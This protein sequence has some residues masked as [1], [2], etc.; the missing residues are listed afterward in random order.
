MAV[1]RVTYKIGD[2]DLIL[3]TGKIG[4]QANGCVYAQY[5]GTS[6]IATVCASSEVKEGLD[7]VPVTVEYNEKYYAA[8]KIPGG[9][10]KR[11]GRPKDKE[12]LVSR[13]IDRPMRPLFEPAFGR[14]IQI[15]PTC[16]SADGINPPDILAV[17]ASSAAVSISDIPFHG[18]V[19]AARVAYIDGQYVIN[20]TFYQQEKAQLE[21]VVAGTK[22]GFT[23]VEGG[24]N[25]VS[26]EVMLG[27]LEQAQGFITAMCELQEQLVA[28]CGKEKLPLAP[29]NV[30]L[31]NKEQIIADATPLLEKACF[32]DGKMARGKAIAAAKEQVAQKYAEQLS[33]EIQKK[34]FDSCFDDIQYNLLR[35]SILD[36]GLRIDGRK[37]DEIRPITCEVNVL[38][39]PHGSA[40]FTRGETQSLA[41]CTLGT[42][43]DA[44]VYDDIDGERS[45]NFILHYN[46]PPYSVGEVGRLTTG[47]REIGHGNLARRSLAAMVPPVTEFPYT[48]RVVSEIMESNGSSS[49][50]STCGGCLAMLAAGVPMKK[51]VAGI[52]MGLITEPEGDNPYGNYKILSDILGEEDHLGDMDFKVAGTKDGITG[53]QMDIKIAGVTTQIMKEALA[54]AKAGRLHILSI[55]EK[56]IDKPQPISP[57]APKILTMKISPDKIG[58]L[59]GPGGKN[60]KALCAQYGVTINTED[61]GTV[62]IYGKTG[63]S[64]EEA[65]LAVKGI[66]EDPEIGTIYNGTVKRIMDFGAFV[67]ILPGK[68]GLCHISKLSRQRVE[69]VSDV[70]KEGQQIPVKLLEV[71]KMGRLNLS[72]VDALE[73]QKK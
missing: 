38:P 58:A 8:G 64:A 49:Q 24:A 55:M 33:D 22:D 23:M 59:I 42:T 45:E 51:M 9:F 29:L 36:K 57:F 4:K 50:A 37:C 25:E 41:V 18:P 13:L 3:E 48:V 17:I 69:K 54:Q 70:L 21:I 47:R 61:D 7:F 35:K 46:F 34:L 44:Q 30:E 20:P 68:E 27:A 32:Q 65:R 43:L 11:E 63:K 52:A 39:R 15:V 12:I 16:V 6:V 40:L 28:K 2:E 53:F 5:A 62:Q 72:Y 1:N 56:C 14:E 26:E 19:A 67:E 71:D 60:I 66:C 31:A 10:V 73:E